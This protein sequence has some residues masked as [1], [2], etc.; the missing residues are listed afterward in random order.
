[1][2]SALTR[3]ELAE[4]A[5]RPL[6]RGGATNPDVL[7]VSDG[8]GHRLIVKDYSQRSLL[9]RRL[10]APMLVCHELT[11]LERL[12]GLPGLPAPRGRIDR[13]AL[14]MEYID[15]IP[16][17]R[18]SHRAALPRAFFDGLEGILEGMALRG[19]IY[20]D[21]RSSTN[22]LT[23]RESDAPALVDL[24]AAYRVPLP[25]PLLAWWDRRALDKLRSRFER[26]EGSERQWQEP[27]DT[28]ELDLGRVRLSFLDQGRADDPVPALFLHDVAH[29]GEIFR[30]LLEA[31]AAHARRGIAPDLPGFG[32]SP[33]SVRRL[34]PARVA[35]QLERFVD[36][37]RISRVDLVGH[38]WGGLVARAFAQRRPGRVRALVTLDSP[39]DRVD[40]RYLRRGRE[41]KRH[42]DRLRRRLMRELPTELNGERRHRVADV[43]E[44]TPARSLAAVYRGLPVRRGSDRRSSERRLR[45]PPPRLPFLAVVSRPVETGPRSA[46]PGGPRAE[47]WPQP[48]ADPS[49][50]WS[51]L[52]KLARQRPTGP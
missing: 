33:W 1:M 18:R 5:V 28:E 43:I 38:G 35:R 40:A 17:R 13:L 30:P 9:V 48:L 7:V 31:A 32:G 21:L 20:F 8:S 51:A 41:A 6:N 39:L 34:P 45:L 16:L 4:R 11:M 23:T 10:L 49:R 25:A 12:A 15:G 52:E 36:A 2:G 29:C 19:V 37:L 50:L 3:A 44:A 22:V 47:W 14:A 26:R 46:A 42:P 24:A 27:P